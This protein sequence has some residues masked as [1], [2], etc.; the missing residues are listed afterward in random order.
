M[1]MDLLYAVRDDR[2]DQC[3]L[4]R[5]SEVTAGFASFSSIGRCAHRSVLGDVR[6]R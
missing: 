5:V 2:I 3:A 1:L 6:P 4:R